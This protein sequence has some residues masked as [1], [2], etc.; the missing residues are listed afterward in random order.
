MTAA[1]VRFDRLALAQDPALALKLSQ[2]ASTRTR[3]PM[4]SSLK[5]ANVGHGRWRCTEDVA[6][7]PQ[8]TLPPPGDHSPCLHCLSMPI[9]VVCVGACVHAYVRVPAARLCACL[10]GCDV[11]VWASAWV[12]VCVHGCLGV[13]AHVCACTYRREYPRTS[14]LSR[15]IPELAC[16]VSLALS[17]VVSSMRAGDNLTLFENTKETRIDYNWSTER[18]R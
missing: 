12:R 9:T 10:G 8:I 6:L 1:D 4:A 7:S 18:E 14:I 2:A 11:G 16:S 17:L 15:N 3:P 13:R 5:T